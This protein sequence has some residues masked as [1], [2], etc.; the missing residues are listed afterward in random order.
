MKKILILL[1]IILIGCK[2]E[3]KVDNKSNETEVIT[4][5]TT[6]LDCSKGLVLIMDG[7][8]I[9]SKWKTENKDWIC[10]TLPPNDVNITVNLLNATLATDDQLVAN[11]L[12]TNSQFLLHE[13]NYSLIEKVHLKSAQGDID[14]IKDKITQGNFTSF[15]LK[16]LKEMIVNF[17][18]LFYE[19]YYNFESTNNKIKVSIV[20]SYTSGMKCFSLPFFKSIIYEN[21]IPMTELGNYT[22]KVVNFDNN[23]F[24]FEISN[25]GGFAKYYNYSTEPSNP[26]ST[27]TNPFNIKTLFL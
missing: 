5:R 6:N 14:K 24:A 11:W 16:S 12:K 22:L 2:G 18:T 19:K 4:L 13:K 23:T 20:D 3:R 7:S 15:K 25:T 26:G 17:D 27:L 8:K 9:D 1:A 21:K 10:D